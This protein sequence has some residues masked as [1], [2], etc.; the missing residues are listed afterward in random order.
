M[1]DFDI[2]WVEILLFGY[3]V[4]VCGNEGKLRLRTSSE[5]PSRHQSETNTVLDSASHKRIKR[6][7]ARPGDRLGY[8]LDDRGI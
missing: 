1:A 4:E 2:F 7:T 8:G 6:R 3:F 5:V